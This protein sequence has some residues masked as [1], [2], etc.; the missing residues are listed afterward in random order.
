[1]P[2]VHTTRYTASVQQCEVTTYSPFLLLGHMLPRSSDP[3]LGC[4]HPLSLAEEFFG[5]RP[6]FAI[7]TVSPVFILD[8]ISS[9]AQPHPQDLHWLFRP[10]AAGS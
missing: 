7:S 2:R 9:P 8:L 5:G 1:M 6:P 10:Y 3:W 4:C